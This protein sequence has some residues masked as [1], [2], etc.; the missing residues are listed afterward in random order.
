MR[1]HVARA[2]GPASLG[3]LEPM[4]VASRL[5]ALLAPKMNMRC[6]SQMRWAP[7]DR[8]LPVGATRPAAAYGRHATGLGAAAASHSGFGKGRDGLRRRTRRSAALTPRAGAALG[9]DRGLGPDSNP[10]PGC[11]GGV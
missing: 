11:A 5:R 9:S 1:M 7:R 6:S 10:E 4:V 2:F 8:P 3:Q